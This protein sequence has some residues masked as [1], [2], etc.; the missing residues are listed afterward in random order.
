MQVQVFVKGTYADGGSCEGDCTAT[1]SKTMQIDTKQAPQE[2]FNLVPD[3]EALDHAM[4][5]VLDYVWE[6]HVPAEKR[7]ESTKL[8]VWCDFDY[9]GTR[10]HV[11]RDWQHLPPPPQALDQGQRG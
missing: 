11:E 7:N 6:K 2:R 10:F 4:R 5:S 3:L 9:N 8:R 1:V